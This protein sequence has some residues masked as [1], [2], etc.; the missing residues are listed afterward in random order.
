[1]TTI[2]VITTAVFFVA[3]I[4]AEVQWRVCKRGWSL[5]NL[6]KNLVREDRDKAQKERDELRKSL[7]G[8]VEAV[9]VEREA[10][11]TTIYRLQQLF[12]DRCATT[13]SR[14][15]YDYL[16]DQ[17]LRDKARKS[18]DAENNR[19]VMGQIEIAPEATAYL[20]TFIAEHVPADSKRD[21]NGTLKEWPVETSEAEEASE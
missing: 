2:L 5:T 4:H 20:D 7:A 15:V 13:W 1:M 6:L 10:R 17:D 14:H 16:D 21:A 18:Y 3:W 19:R 11:Q 8:V 12:R 9:K